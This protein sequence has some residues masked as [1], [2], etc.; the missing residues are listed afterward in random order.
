MADEKSEKKKPYLKTYGKGK[1][2]T[3]GKAFTKERPNSAYCCKECKRKN[4]VK[5]Q[6]E[7]SRRRYK[8][9]PEFR[10]KAREH[11]RKYYMKMKGLDV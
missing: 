11:C 3:C 8:A 9:D 7:Y 6:V 1:C 5:L 10:A 2:K 4:D